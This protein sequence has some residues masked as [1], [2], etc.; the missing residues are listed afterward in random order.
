MAQRY[1]MK[2]NG[3][4]WGSVGG[5]STMHV[6]D[7]EFLESMFAWRNKRSDRWEFY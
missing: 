7:L 1:A 4:F 2:A 5:W 6:I 3:D